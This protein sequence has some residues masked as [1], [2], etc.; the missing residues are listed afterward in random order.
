[1]AMLCCCGR[2][3]LADLHPRQ[4]VLLGL[5]LRCADGGHVGCPDQLGSSMVVLELRGGGGYRTTWR[6]DVRKK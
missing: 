4:H 2:C 6:G 5:G 3:I 1:M